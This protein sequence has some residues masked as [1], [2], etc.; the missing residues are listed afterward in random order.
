MTAI[1]PEAKLKPWQKAVEKIN[2]DYA[3]KKAEVTKEEIDK[4]IEDIAKSRVQHVTV[5]R[6]AKEGDNVILDFEVN[7]YILSGCS[8]NVI[9][10]FFC[11]VAIFTLHLYQ[12]LSMVANFIPKTISP[13]PIQGA[14]IIITESLDTSPNFSMCV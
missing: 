8:P 1:V 7:S 6:E 5:E 4:E 2:K 13:N 12:F 14:F 9:K 10:L 3:N 11:V